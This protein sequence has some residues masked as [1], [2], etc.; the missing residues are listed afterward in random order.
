MAK[1]KLTFEEEQEKMQQE[2]AEQFLENLA[3]S[4]MLKELAEATKNVH[5][6]DVVV[7]VKEWQHPCGK[8]KA[9]GT[10]ISVDPE[11][12]EELIKGKFI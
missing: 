5:G 11:L 3:V 9:I 6:G 2:K 12:R 8:I 1:R 7:L 10:E 4:G